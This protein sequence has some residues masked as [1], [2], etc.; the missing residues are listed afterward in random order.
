MENKLSY[1]IKNRDYSP[2]EGELFIADYLQRQNI[3]FEH[4]SAIVNLINDSKKHRIADFYLPNYKCYVEFYGLWNNK[5]EDRIRYSEKKSVFDQNKIPCVYLYPENLGIIEFV[6]PKRMRKVLKNHGLKKEL[7]RFNLF[8]FLKE[9]YENIFFLILGIIA[10]LFLLK[11]GE[12]QFAFISQFV[13]LFFA[14]K[15][16]LGLNKHFG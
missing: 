8:S 2:S 9:Y 11:I 13:L 6:F 4:E 12:I 1:N 10:T 5:K 7:F 16:V 3:K 15:V 14:V